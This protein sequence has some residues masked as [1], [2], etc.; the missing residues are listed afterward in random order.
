MNKALM[1][2]LEA[3]E[4]KLEL[5]RPPFTW[6][7]EEDQDEPGVYFESPGDGVRMTEEEVHQE[8]ERRLPPGKSTHKDGQDFLI[9]VKHD[10]LE[11][12]K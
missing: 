3:I 11:T 5:H 9:I 6:V 1:A 4:Q 2:R 8:F 10:R 7:V 12:K